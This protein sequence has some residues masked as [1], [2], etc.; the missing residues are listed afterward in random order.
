MGMRNRAA[1][2]LVL[3]VILIL[4]L[5]LLPARR[6]GP[7]KARAQRI[8]T[9]NSLPSVSITLTKTNALSGA[10]PGVGK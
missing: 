5:A 2:W 9:V 7:P 4:V 3:A 8:S 1:I 6:T 10:Q